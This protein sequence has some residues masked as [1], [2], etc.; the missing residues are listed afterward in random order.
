MKKFLLELMNRLLHFIAQS[1]DRFDGL[2][3]VNES[4]SFFLVFFPVKTV[5]DFLVS[6]S[7]QRDLA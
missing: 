4:I 3:R 6:C 5:Y 1:I 2:T 7:L